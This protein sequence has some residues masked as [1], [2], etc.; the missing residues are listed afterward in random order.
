MSRLAPAPHV[1]A[2][3][4]PRRKPLVGH[5]GRWGREPLSLLREGAALGGVF[6]LRLWRTVVVGYRPQW[7]R[8][9]L[10]DLDTFRSAGS[11]SRLTPY[12]AGGV[13]LLDAPGHRPRRGEL[14]PHVRT[15]SLGHLQQELA[16]V[17]D[18]ALPAGSFE[19]LGWASAVVR[20]MLNQVFFGG[21]MDER[22]L[23]SFLEPLHLGFPHPFLPRRRLFRRMQRAIEAAVAAPAPGSLADALRGL[24]GAAE[25]LRV[26]LAAGFDT[27]AHTLAWA[28]WHLAGH[29][30][31][32]DPAA[33]PSVINETLR[34][35]PAGWVGSRVT[36]REIAT[37]D[38]VLPAGTM[39]L[40]SPYL[41]HRDPQLWAAPHEFDPA[42]FDGPPPSWGYLPFGGGERH[43][44]G[45]H[46][47][48]LML[49]IALE[50]FCAADLVPVHG[51]P[52]PRAGLTLRPSGPLVVARAGR[53]Q[54]A[55]MGNGG[56]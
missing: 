28:V 24:D 23:A 36:S 20:A 19:T 31:W 51:D 50:P 43:C 42:R 11:L 52:A 38:A 15:R 41:S 6:R 47:A 44:L 35:Y 7:N 5:L 22:L 49:R 26:A 30:Q 34:L 16:E 14:N 40:Y 55:G 10:R 33:L 2:L 8:L 29:P 25:E 18:R 4:A 56:G 21:R 17:A 1:A 39:V 53:A 13:V 32:R 27:T 54:R 45:A 46:L 37:A 48:R 12:L 9:L 3:P